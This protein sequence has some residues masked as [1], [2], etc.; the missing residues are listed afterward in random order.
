MSALKETEMSQKIVHSLR[1]ADSIPEAAQPVAFPQ[2]TTNRVTGL[3][4]G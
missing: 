4:E 3:M 2:I 1:V